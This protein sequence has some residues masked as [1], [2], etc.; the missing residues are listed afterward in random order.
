[1]EKEYEVLFNQVWLQPTFKL[2]TSFMSTV[3]SYVDA[4][5]MVVWDKSGS[6]C[7]LDCKHSGVQHRVMT[8]LQA[9]KWG[10]DSGIPGA[11]AARILSVQR[12]VRGFSFSQTEVQG[13]YQ[14][15]VKQSQR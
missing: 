1:M 14:L 10:L 7:D 12:L 9:K 4:D 6:V 2:H 11:A 5:S 8:C 13:F 3:L 15:R